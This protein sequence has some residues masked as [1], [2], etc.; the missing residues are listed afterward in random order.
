MSLRSATV[1]MTGPHG[2]FMLDARHSGD[3]RVR[4][5]RHG[6]AAVMPMLGKLA[7]RPSGRATFFWGPQPDL[8]ARGGIAALARGSRRCPA[9]TSGPR[10]VGGRGR[11]IAAVLEAL[12]CARRRSAWSATA[13]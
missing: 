11:I 8:F 13:P 12:P 3:S 2:F 6:I 7:R 1:N 5:H 4:R 10:L 9:L